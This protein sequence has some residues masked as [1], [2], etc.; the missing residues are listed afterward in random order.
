MTYF[1]D[2]FLIFGA[3]FGPAE[4]YVEVSKRLFGL[5]LNQIY[6]HQL[7]PVGP[8]HFGPGLI[9]NPLLSLLF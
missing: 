2:N 4:T 9:T 5:V 8:A 3:L 1:P 6:H 7:N